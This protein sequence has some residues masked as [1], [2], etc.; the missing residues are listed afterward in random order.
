MI[1]QN[2][3]YEY[4][5]VCTYNNVKCW[6]KKS[7]GKWYRIKPETY[8]KETGIKFNRSFDWNSSSNNNYIQF[9]K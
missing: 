1:K 9:I 2:T 8:Y 6:K 7:G 4:K 5:I 3:D